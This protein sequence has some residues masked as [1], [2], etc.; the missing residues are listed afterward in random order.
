MDRAWTTLDDRW[1]KG[2]IGGVVHSWSK[3][4]LSFG[5]KIGIVGQ[6]CGPLLAVLGGLCEADGGCRRS[7]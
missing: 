7:G 3:V 4:G 5:G 1:T 2:A 6:Q